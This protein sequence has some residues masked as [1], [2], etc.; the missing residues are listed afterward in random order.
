[1]FIPAEW[2]TRQESNADPLFCRKSINSNA[3][4]LRDVWK[5]KE[6]IKLV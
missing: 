5:G 2:N 1:M 6:I 3:M 4:V